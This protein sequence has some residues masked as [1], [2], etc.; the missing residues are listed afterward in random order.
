MA[1]YADLYHLISTFFLNALSLEIPSVDTD[2]VDAGILDSMT[3]VELLLFLGEKLGLEIPVEDIEI[4]NFRSIAKMID[5]II[6][7]GALEGIT[8]EE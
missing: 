2:L 6:H 3:F 7:R 8:K 4:D 1:K 5:F